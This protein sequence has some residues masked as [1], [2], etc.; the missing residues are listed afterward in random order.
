MAEENYEQLSVDIA[1]IF[2][3]DI[4]KG[5]FDVEKNIEQFRKKLSDHIVHLLEKDYHRLLAILYRVDVD[6]QKMRDCLG[7]ADLSEAADCLAS[8]IIERQMEKIRY[9]NSE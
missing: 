5:D 3:P 6:E 8:A 4:K 1:K 2:A 7:G 9:R